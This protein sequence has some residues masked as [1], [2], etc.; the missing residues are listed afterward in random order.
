MSNQI[1]TPVLGTK[2]NPILIA[3]QKI[4]ELKDGK[5]YHFICSSCRKEVIKGFNKSR[6]KTIENFLLCQ[7]CSCGKNKKLYSRR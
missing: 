5:Y 3:N 2:E 4:E 6:H 1:S 7:K